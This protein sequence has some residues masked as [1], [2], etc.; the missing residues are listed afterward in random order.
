MGGRKRGD[1]E[2]GEKKI[3]ARAQTFLPL[4]YFTH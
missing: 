4:C 3:I 2:N 1:E